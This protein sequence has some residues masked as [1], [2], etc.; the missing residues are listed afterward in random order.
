MK[1]NGVEAGSTKWLHADDAEWQ[2][3][4]LRNG[5]QDLSTQPNWLRRQ[6]ATCGA[7]KSVAEH[8]CAV[9]MHDLA[10][11]I[12]LRCPEAAYRRERRIP[13]Y[14]G[15]I[16]GAVLSKGQTKQ[17][18]PAHRA[19]GELASAGEFQSDGFPVH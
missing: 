18:R 1:G 16:D 9:R 6:G 15:L 19:A 14:L 3:A 13:A 10:D 7:I 8:Q 11:A 2:I 17:E 12:R 4:L 5:N